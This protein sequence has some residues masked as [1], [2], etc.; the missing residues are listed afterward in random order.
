MDI[1][2]PSPGVKGGRGVMLTTQPYL[3]P[4]LRKNMSYTFSSLPKQFHGR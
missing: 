1:G 2:G 4:M 3:V